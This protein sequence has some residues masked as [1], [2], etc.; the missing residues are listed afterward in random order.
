MVPRRHQPCEYLTVA[1]HWKHDQE[2]RWPPRADEL[3][4]L[5]ATVSYERKMMLAATYKLRWPSFPDIPI[6]ENQRTSALQ[7]RLHLMQATSR[8]R[9]R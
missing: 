8:I 4:A 2:F 1:N 9:T 3:V 6:A 5:A 7:P